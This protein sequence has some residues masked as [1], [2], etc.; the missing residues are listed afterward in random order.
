MQITEITYDD[1]VPIDG[2][3]PG[4][5]R[6]GGQVLHGPA[7]VTASGAGAWGGLEDRAPLMALAGRIDVLLV[8]TGPEMA[9]LPK[10]FAS[11]LE[12]LGIGVEIMASP[13]ACRTYNMLLAEARRVA[14]AL[15]PA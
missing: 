4:Y 12:E 6:V 3:G 5:F 2:Y 15:L 13:S 9:P 7:L 10:G 14:A 8:G 11:A 1:A